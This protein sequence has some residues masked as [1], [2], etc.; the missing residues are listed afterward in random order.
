METISVGKTVDLKNPNS[1][2]S[3]AHDYPTAL[4]LTKVNSI[5]ACEH[6]TAS[7]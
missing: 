4:I 7:A 1:L 2:F 5:A 3:S 6:E